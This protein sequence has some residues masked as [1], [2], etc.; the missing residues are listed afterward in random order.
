MLFVGKRTHKRHGLQSTSSRKVPRNK[1]TIATPVSTYPAARTQHHRNKISDWEQLWSAKNDEG[2]LV[3]FAPEGFEYFP[4]WP[5]PEYAQ[6][7]SDINFPGHTAIE[8]SIHELIE[9]WLP[10]FE[11][12]KIQVAVFPNKEWEF[13]CIK[14]NDLKEDLLNEMAQYE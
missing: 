12:D 13:W 14:P 1:I 10:L 5:H 6:K 4:L 8:I 9:H 2:W 3:P 7:V 11:Q